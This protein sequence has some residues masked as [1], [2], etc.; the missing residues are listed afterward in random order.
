[1]RRTCLL[2][3]VLIAL[4]S[5]AFAYVTT[6]AIFFDHMVLQRGMDVPVWGW[7]DPGEKVTVSFAGQEVTATADAD[8]NW[9]VRLAPLAASD[10]PRE[11]VVAGSA[12]EE[13]FSDVLVGEVW[14]C[15]GQS[16]MQWPVQ[17]SQDAEG[18]I[19]AADLPRIRLFTVQNVTADEPQRDTKATWK[20]CTPESVRDFSA[21]G[22]FFGRSLLEHLDVPVGLI[23]SSWG[24]TPAESWTSR[25]RLL[26]HHL[27]R[28]IVRQWDRWVE[29]YDPDK[30]REEHEARL[31]EWKK[32]AEVA[33]EAGEQ[34]PRLPRLNDPRTNPHRP[35]SLYNAMIAPIIPYAIRGAI[36][37]QGESNAGRAFQYRTLFP[38]MIRDW[39]DRWG[40]GDFPFLFVQ[41]ANFLAVQQQPVQADATWPFLREAQLLTLELPDTGMASAID[42]G[43]AENIHP[44]NKQEVG[45]RLALAAR[46]L[47]YGEDVVYSGPIARADR[48]KIQDGKA[49]LT[50]DHVGSGLRAIN[51]ALPEG[52]PQDL[53]ESQ[54]LG[55]AIAGEDRQWH[56]ARAEITGPDTVVV[57][58]EAVPEPVAVRYGWA[59]NPFGNLENSGGLPAS[60]F[61]TDAWPGR[62]GR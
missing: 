4:A 60:P 39:R 33:R 34:P 1:M 8:G 25:E 24:G 21:V 44:K 22:F 9:S 18:E 27:L 23:D 3:A 6:P 7:A 59:N 12:N 32:Q 14:V 11:L 2:S 62:D 10:E 49:V 20:V 28:P 5:P 52:A 50:F 31:E 15:S 58:S 37:Y 38:V 26:E 54:L 48:A 16:N 47:A 57:W 43:E 40:Q 53:P 55:F 30:A 41:L 46:A 13:R 19:A 17:A 61:R 29:G 51:R 36:W 56:W 35:A 45:R 42:V